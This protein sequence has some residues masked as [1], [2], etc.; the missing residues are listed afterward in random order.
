MA[1]VDFNNRQ[2][3]KI[4]SVPAWVQ[5][6]VPAVVEEVGFYDREVGEVLDDTFGVSSN[7]EWCSQCSLHS[8]VPELQV[9][10]L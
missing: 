9:R 7:W 10:W 5:E 6:Q 1:A 4:T 3:D 8:F 2:L